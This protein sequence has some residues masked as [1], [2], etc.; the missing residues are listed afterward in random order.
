[1]TRAAI[2]LA[3]GRSSRMGQPKAELTLDGTPFLL[4]VVAAHTE[5]VG[6]A[7]VVVVRAAGQLLPPLPD[8]VKITEDR[9]PGRGPLEG[10]A[11]GLL[12]LPTGVQTLFLAACDTPLLSPAFVRLLFDRLE[13]SICWAVV[14]DALN[15]RHPLSAAYRVQVQQSVMAAIAAGELAMGQLLARLPVTTVDEP[16]LRAVDADL[17][18]LRNV[19][20]PAEYAEMVAEWG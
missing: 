6:A 19:N 1:M 15:H 17:V 18:S 20:T 5:V 16:E 9:A 12:A 4:R 13:S 2:V 14:P 11:A 3:G 10:F 8:G 7:N